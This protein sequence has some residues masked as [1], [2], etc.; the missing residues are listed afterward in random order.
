MIAM[1]AALVGDFTGDGQTDA[2]WWTA[3]Q[4]STLWLAD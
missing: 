1:T 2:L 4:P 3:G